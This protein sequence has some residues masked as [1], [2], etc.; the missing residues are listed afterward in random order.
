MP[1]FTR[2]E[3]EH[4]GDLA[5]IALTDEEAIRLQGE[6]NVIAESINKV[7]EVARDDVQPTANPVPLEAYMRP[8][9]ART[10]LTQEEALSG[11]P[12]SESGMFVAPRILGEE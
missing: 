1:T 3:I 5:R 9:V 11:A 8:D 7:Q 2:E 12:L 10:P 6:L 4:L